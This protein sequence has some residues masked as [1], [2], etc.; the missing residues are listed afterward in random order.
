VAVA[1]LRHYLRG[2]KPED[3]I[4]RLRAGAVDGGAGDV[5]VHPDEVHALEWMLGASR[6]GDVVAVAALSQR[7]EIFEFLSERRARQ[8]GP[9]RVR[10]LVR[11]ARGATS[12]GV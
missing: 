5:P 9:A 4:G 6:P 7:F 3:V 12:V 2:A 10:Q 1:E 11:R 8:A